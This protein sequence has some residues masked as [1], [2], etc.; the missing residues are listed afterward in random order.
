MVLFLEDVRGS[1][2]SIFTTMFTVCFLQA[3]NTDLPATARIVCSPLHSQA[4]EQRAA[5]H[6]AKETIMDA[7]K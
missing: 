7:R 4:R 2:N 1:S 5:R 6:V 3:R